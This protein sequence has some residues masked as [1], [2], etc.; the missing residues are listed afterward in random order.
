MEAAHQVIDYDATPIG[1]LSVRRQVEEALNRLSLNK[2][3]GVWQSLNR[4][5]RHFPTARTIV[6]GDLHELTEPGG[7]DYLAAGP[8]SLSFVL[9]V[10]TERDR[11]HLFE[12]DTALRLNDDR[13]FVLDIKS[14]GVSEPSMAAT[15]GDYFRAFIDRLQ[16]DRVRTARFSSLD[17]VL[18]VEFGD[19]LERAVMWSSLPF[20]S[21][22]SFAPAAASAREHG[23]SVLLIDA[24]GAE[25]DVDAGAL[26][27]A[28]DAGQLAEIDGQ[29]RAERVAAGA[30]IRSI[31]D[32]LGL[33]QEEVALRSGI[34]QESLSRIE[35]GH[36]DPRLDTLRKLASGLAMD[37]SDLLSRMAVDVPN[38][39]IEPTA[40]APSKRKR[41]TAAHL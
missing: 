7:L 33:S 21:R 41:L 22:L 12:P 31:R 3:D 14:G 5:H 10:R 18:W 13:F 26:R 2:C 4:T 40:P 27:G 36:R 20:A 23:Q 37:V 30:R 25:L 8:S 38:Q 6:V 34:P 24:D 11:K 17:G 9:L 16:P 29:H 39:E 19:G 1:S 28:L 32:G 35:N 15:L